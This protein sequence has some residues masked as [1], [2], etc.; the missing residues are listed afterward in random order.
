MIATG[1]N[2]FKYIGKPYEKYNCLDLVKEVYLD[3][4]G[5]TIKD[6]FEGPVPDRANVEALIVSNK[7]EFI[8]V[9]DKPQ[10]GDIVVIRLYGFECHIGVCIDSKHFIHSIKTSGSCMERLE[11]YHHMIT[12][13]YRHKATT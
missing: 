3:N 2:L 12:G 7:G 9:D 1:I 11:R 6:Y 13:Y 4:F 10:F 5:I 8:S